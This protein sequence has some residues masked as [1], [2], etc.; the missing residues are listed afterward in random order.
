MPLWGVPEW[1][2]SPT[3]NPPLPGCDVAN[4]LADLWFRMGFL[5]AND[6]NVDDRWVTVD[7]LY[8]FGDEAVKALARSSLVFLTYDTSIAVTPPTA[9]YALPAG[10]VLTEG[11]WLLYAGQPLQLLRLT[12]VGQLFALDSEWSA[13]QGNPTRLSLDAAGVPNCVL[14]PVPTASATLAQV[15]QALP[16]DV[17]A[18][19]SSL[20]LSP[21]L[22]DAFTYACLGAARG[23]ESDSRMDEIAAHCKERVDLYAKVAAH[24]WGSAVET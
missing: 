7:E 13:T 9:T 10:H 14:Y 24:L 1:G 15:M 17:I 16:P 21:V 19:A 23:K 20:P 8:E 6:A 3:V 2:E 18:G 5:D 11:A 12:S 22:Q 4:C